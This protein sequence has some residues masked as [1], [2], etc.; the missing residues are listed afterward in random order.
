MNHSAAEPQPNSEPRHPRLKIIA[1]IKKAA[2]QILFD[3]AFL[4]AFVSLWFKTV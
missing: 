4:C 1:E 2:K 3:A